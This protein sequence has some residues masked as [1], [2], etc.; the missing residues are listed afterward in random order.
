MEL[1]RFEEEHNMKIN[2]L[3]NFGIDADSVRKC[4]RSYHNGEITANSENGYTT[5][6]INIK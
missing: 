5:F 1:K 2:E 3:S 4:V 6:K